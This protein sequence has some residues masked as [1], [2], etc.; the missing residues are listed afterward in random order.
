MTKVSRACHVDVAAKKLFG[1]RIKQLEKRI[2]EI[3]AA[4]DERKNALN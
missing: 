4:V 3:R 1:P 2:G